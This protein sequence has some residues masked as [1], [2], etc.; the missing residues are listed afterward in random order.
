MSDKLFVDKGGEIDE[1][2]GK[3][4]KHVRFP[5][6]L[7]VKYGED[8]PEACADFILNISKGGVFIKTDRPLKN[9]S[10][11]TMHFYI[12]P[13]EKLLGEFE[14]EV[15]GLSPGIPP[16]PGGMHVKFVNC[17]EEDMKRLEDFLEE[18]KHLV[19]KEA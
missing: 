14:G 17:S 11:I 12:P 16:L 3:E 13:E 1:F 18:K 4:R 10:K 7:A 5:V 6:C 8:V 19:D 9:G 15:V 2:A